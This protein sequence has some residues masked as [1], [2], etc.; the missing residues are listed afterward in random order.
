MNLYEF[1]QNQDG[2]NINVSADGR[3]ATVKYIHTALDWSDKR[4]RMARGIVLD[5]VTGEVVA[6]P[7]EKFFNLGQVA[8]GVENPEVAKLVSWQPEPFAV[9]EK[10]DGS[11]AI[12]YAYDGELHVGSTGNP[13]FVDVNSGAVI[14]DRLKAVLSDADYRRVKDLALAGY[15]LLFEYLN[16]EYVIV[17]NY[18]D[19]AFKLHGMVHTATGRDFTPDELR[20]LKLSDDV[21]APV[22]PE[23]R[24]F[25][26][27]Q[28][29]LD[30]HQDIEGFVI[31]FKSGLRLKLKTE[32]YKALHKTFSLFQ[33]NTRASR[34]LMLA[35]YDLDV[36]DD[37]SADLLLHPDANKYQIAHLRELYDQVREFDEKIAQ[38]DALR[39]RYASVADYF[40][41]TDRANSDPVI[42]ALIGAHGDRHDIQRL[43]YKFIVGV[44]ISNEGFDV[45]D[46]D[47]TDLVG[48]ELHVKR[49][50]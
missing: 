3:R 41:S 33:N 18:Q 39:A 28:G 38:A 7:Y 20:G 9:S 4:I 10:M 25:D 35:L 19:E 6:R 13:D 47:V 43:R 23:L 15:T 2:L 29:Y 17:I 12:V 14:A 40:K 27:V 50:Y 49:D 24:S 5:T 34:R 48:R 26:D 42:D 37:L 1:Y 32:Q 11:L 16:P 45:L 31:R 22:Y 8:N 44:G 21:L 30:N 46:Q 36:L